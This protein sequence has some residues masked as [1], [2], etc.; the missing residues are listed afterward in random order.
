MS[1]P[2]SFIDEVNEE[3]QRDRLF[4][5]L[6]KYGWIGIA[7]V[8]LLV[9]GAA[10]NE[11]NKARAIARAEAFGDAVFAA[12]DSEDIAERRTALQD[13][14]VPEDATP[15]AQ[16]M[17][18]AQ[19]E[20]AAAAVALLDALAA[21]ADTP[22]LYR[23]LAQLRAVLVGAAVLDT[24]ELQSRL[25]SLIAQNGP[26]TILARE[27][28]ALVFLQNGNNDAAISEL[29]AVLRSAEASQRLRQRASQMIVAA[30]G[31]PENALN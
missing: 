25:E 29:E 23:Q 22:D 27:Q 20:D 5:V 4:A 21:D 2:E 14:K 16:L 19:T 6:R 12:L 13:I 15:V 8:V 31:N 1:N 24:A 17:V 11:W 7:L 10:V 26:F 28:L 18:S 9:G 30:G 3:L